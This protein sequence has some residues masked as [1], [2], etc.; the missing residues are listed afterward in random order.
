MV[1]QFL[2]LGS[3]NKKVRKLV[4]K[5]KNREY[6]GPSSVSF[7]IFLKVH[8][9]NPHKHDMNEN[10][11]SIIRKIQVS[12]NIHCLHCLNSVSKTADSYPMF[13][14][15]EKILSFLHGVLFPPCCYLCQNSPETHCYLF[16]CL[17]PTNLGASSKGDSLPI[18]FSFWD[19]VK[20]W[21]RSQIGIATQLQ[22]G[23]YHLWFYMT[24]WKL[25]SQSSWRNYRANVP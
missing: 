11:C 13:G 1:L 12:I 25:N 15:S 2:K 8:T 3:W 22:N 23:S 20:V 7:P 16:C 9:E 21:S 4:L 6:L 5:R 24:K 10:N 14:T 17:C 19:S 18:F